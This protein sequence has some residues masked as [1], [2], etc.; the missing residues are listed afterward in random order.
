MSVVLA[1]PA[2][3]PFPVLLGNDNWALAAIPVAL[4][5]ELGWVLSRQPTPTEGD[6]VVV[7]GNKTHSKRRR[8]ARECLWVIAPP[9]MRGPEL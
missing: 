6:H 2:R 9:S 3:D 5:R 7:I 8:V 1:T 4:I